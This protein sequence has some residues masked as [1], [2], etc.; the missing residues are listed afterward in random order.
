MRETVVSRA[1]REGF[2]AW[3][4]GTLAALFLV[5]ISGFSLVAPGPAQAQTF[6]FTDIRVDGVDR[7]DPA[8]VAAY[9]GIA[10]GQ[11][12]S[13][14]QLNAAYQG[15][16]NSGLFESVEI[17][18]RGNTLIIRV[19]EWPTINIINFEG[20]R[21]IDNDDLAAVIQSESRRVYSP[22]V[23]EADAAAITELYRQRG[24]FAVEVTPRIIRA[25]ATGSIWCSAWR[26]GSVVEIERISFVGNR[27][28]SDYRLRQVLETGRRGSCA[29]SCSATPSSRN[30]SRLTASC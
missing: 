22:A 21:R 12:L 18:P 19:R 6:Q 26:E 9:A 24:R 13:A 8:T 10:R 17:E 28:Y 3:L 14:A 16:V 1:A 30:G 25:R 15:I 4:P 11:T 2:G 27:A 29:G 23:A 5:I 20:N 7:V